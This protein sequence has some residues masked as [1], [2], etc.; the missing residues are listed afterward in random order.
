MHT[1]VCQSVE[2]NR[3]G[4]H[5][6][7]TFTG[8]HFGN[9]SLVKHHTT[10]QLH[11]VVH[12]VP[13]YQVAPGNPFIFKVCFISFNRYKVVLC[14]QI[15]VELSGGN[16]QITV[17]I[18]SACRIFHYGEC[19]G[20][21]L[22]EHNGYFLYNFFFQFIHIVVNFFTKV[23]FGFLNSGFKLFNTFI[24]GSDGFLNSGFEQLG[25]SAK[26]IV[27]Q[28]FNLFIYSLYLSNFRRYFFH[29]ARGF[30]AYYLFQ[31]IVKSHISNNFLLISF[32]LFL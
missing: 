7:F 13:L 31:N 17:F 5:Q 11:I 6:C 20:K 24:F 16:N 32:Q 27:A 15:T 9:F 12:H 29:I 22:V 1:S 21:Y 25:T 14:S 2:E 4:G 28:I 23:E 3:K 10:K 8:S 18:Q 19:L 26:F 30:A